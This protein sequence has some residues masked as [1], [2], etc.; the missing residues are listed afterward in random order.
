MAVYIVAQYL[1]A[2]VASAL[3]FA[4]YFEALEDFEAKTGTNLTRVTPDTAGIWATYPATFL[5]HYSGMLDQVT[6]Y[7]LMRV[8]LSRTTYKLVDQP[9]EH[10][11]PDCRHCSPSPVHLRNL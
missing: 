4:V 2:F 1:G 5:S 6:R 9:R 10:H 3:L 8:T 7:M 11:H